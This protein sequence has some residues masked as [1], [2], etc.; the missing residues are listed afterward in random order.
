MPS[1]RLPFAL[2]AAVAAVA[3]CGG[4]DAGLAELPCDIGI[5]S[6]GVVLR[7][8]TTGRNLPGGP[9]VRDGRGN[10]YG[11]TREG[12]RIARWA[13]DGTPTGVFGTPGDAPGALGRGPVALFVAPGDTFF[14]RDL[15]GHWVVFD[16]AFRFQREVPYAPFRADGT[17]D[18]HFLAGGAIASTNLAPEAGTALAVLDHDGKMLRTGPALGAAAAGTV[19]RP[20]AAVGDGFWVAPVPGTGAPYRLEVWDATGRVID[21]VVRRVPWYVATPPVVRPG[22]ANGMG[23]FPFPLIAQVI[24]G[25]NGTVWVWTAVPT[26]P[27]AAERY[28]AAAPADVGRVAAEVIGFHLEVFDAASRRLLASSEFPLDAARITGFVYAGPG[29]YRVRPRADGGQDV[30]VAELVLRPAGRQACPAGTTR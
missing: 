4:K 20:S 29:V 15:H 21:S 7:A 27:D 24:A 5:D 13:P 17:G 9:I 1:R 23:N 8:D 18:V 30:N 16:S 22:N 2:L 3:A 28:L 19:G 10:L 25:R 11:S 26:A 12:G 6:P 14:V